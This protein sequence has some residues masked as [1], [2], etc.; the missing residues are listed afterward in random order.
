M[1]SSV[2]A[3]ARGLAGS[4]LGQRAGCQPRQ[5]C[6]TRPAGFMVK[7]VL[8]TDVTAI[9][10]KL[11]TQMASLSYGVGVRPQSLAEVVSSGQPAGAET[12]MQQL[13]K[14]RG[15]IGGPHTAPPRPA[16]PPRGFHPPPPPPG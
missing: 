11:P 3:S 16:G 1:V 15:A 14:I 8:M 13:L 9:Y 7:N 2:A 6:P 4:L 12:M 10:P 5:N